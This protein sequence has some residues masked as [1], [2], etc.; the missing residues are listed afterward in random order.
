MIEDLEKKGSERALGLV[1]NV[2]CAGG[3]A[4]I[5]VSLVHPIDLVKTRLQIS[6]EAGR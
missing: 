1:D 5:T 6:G 2:A 4:I 3:A